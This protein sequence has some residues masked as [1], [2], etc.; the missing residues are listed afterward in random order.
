[1]DVTGEGE[2]LTTSDVWK[3][4]LEEAGFVDLEV[5]G[6]PPVEFG[7]KIITGRKAAG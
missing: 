7:V 6:V 5:Q 1:V 4:I 2:Y 3:G